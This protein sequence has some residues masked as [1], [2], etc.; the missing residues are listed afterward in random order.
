[1]RGTWKA[2]DAGLEYTIRQMVEADLP[3][4]AEVEAGVFTDWYRIYRREPEP[5]AERTLEE[6]RYATSLTPE[7]NCVAVAADGSLVGFILALASVFL[8]ETMGPVALAGGLTVIA[9][10]AAL[11]G[12]RGRMVRA[13]R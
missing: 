4:V 8:G 7:A 12:A 5:L 3:V 6:L 11:A 10:G 2:G 13:G 9:G 1:M